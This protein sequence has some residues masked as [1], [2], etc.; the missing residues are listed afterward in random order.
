[1]LGNAEGARGS[2]N[3]GRAV[4]GNVEGARG[5]RAPKITQAPATQAMGWVALFYHD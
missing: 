2:T 1:M 5:S 3:I 4:L